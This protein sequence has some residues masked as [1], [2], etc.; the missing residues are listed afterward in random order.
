MAMA[1]VGNALVLVTVILNR[2]RLVSVSTALYLS[3][4]AFS[5][6]MVGAL[7]MW[8]HLTTGIKQDWPFG[9]ELCK[10]YPFLQSEQSITCYWITGLFA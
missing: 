5:D 4:L 7:V 8:I 1:V 10:A 2:H 6:F 9:S 3:N